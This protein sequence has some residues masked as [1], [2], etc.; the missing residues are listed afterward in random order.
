MPRSSLEIVSRRLEN[1]DSETVPRFFAILC[2][3][4]Q[5][6]GKEKALTGEG[7]RITFR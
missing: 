1:T 6:A 3:S 5:G 7:L 2:A 4:V